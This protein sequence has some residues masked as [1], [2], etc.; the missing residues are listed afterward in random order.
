MKLIAIETATEACSAALWCDGEVREENDLAPNMHSARLLPMLQR[1]LAQAGVS[2]SQCDAVAFGRGPGSFTGLRIGV[3]TAQG[4][5]LGAE[6]PL[7]GV[8]SLQALA[9]RHPH[10][11]VL[12]AF[13]AR[14]GEIYWCSYAPG[15]HGLMLPRQPVTVDRPSDIVVAPAPEYLAVGS[16][17]DRYTELLGRRLGGSRFRHVPGCHP[18]AADVARIAAL[19]YTQGRTLSPEQA[20]PEYIRNRVTAKAATEAGL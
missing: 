8:S 11:C 6:L 9:Q 5:A 3:G 4:L 19:D 18:H 16:G 7:V 10:P 2:L 17:C 12:A 1:L 13:D 14:M 15:P 20:N